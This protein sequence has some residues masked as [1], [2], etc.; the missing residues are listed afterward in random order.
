MPSLLSRG[1]SFLNSTARANLAETVRYIRGAQVIEELKA[2]PG[3]A[4]LEQSVD[5]E[6]TIVGTRHK[7]SFEPDDLLFDNQLTEPQRGDVVEL[8]Q[9]AYVIAFEV[10][11]SE[12]ER[13]W[14]PMGPETAEG[15]RRIGVWT[16]VVERRLAT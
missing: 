3:T 5:G 12:G 1:M 9:G 15:S 14:F 7:W 8:A 4:D 6:V 2:V 13:A 16:K 10:L 11:P